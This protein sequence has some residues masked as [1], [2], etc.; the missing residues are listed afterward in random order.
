MVT[1]HGC[2]PVFMEFLSFAC[3]T[4]VQPITREV[5]LPGEFGVGHFE[6]PQLRRLTSFLPAVLVQ[7]RATSTATTY[8]RAYKSWKVWTE[9][10]SASY[11]PADS[12][13]FTL[14]I[15]SYPADPVSSVNTVYGVSWVHKKSGYPEPS[16]YPRVKQAVDAAWRILARP[17][18]RNEPLPADL[19]RRVV[20]RLEKGSLADIELAV[21]SSVGFFGFL[22]WDDLHRLRV[23]SLHFEESHVAIF[24]EKRKTDQFREG[25]WVFVAR[26]NTPLCPV[27]VLEKFLTVGNHA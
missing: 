23:D 27:A 5:T 17:P 8:L 21:L 2:C 18:Q 4:A 13:V 24:L 19:A 26:C 1:S 11:L 25:S 15:V 9:Q 3:V 12:V 22:R 14:Y 20:S 7:D 16:E 10:H 6:H